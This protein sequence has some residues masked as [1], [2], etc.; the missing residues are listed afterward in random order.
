[1]KLILNS[2]TRWTA[3]ALAVG[4]LLIAAWPGFSAYR[5][6]V[7]EGKPV[8]AQTLSD[9]AKRERKQMEEAA[10]REREMREKEMKATNYAEGKKRDD[11]YE[12]DHDHKKHGDH[13]KMPEY[14]AVAA[15][16]GGALYLADKS[17][18]YRWTEA[19]LVELPRHP[20]KDAQALLAEE[21]VL[22]LADKEGLHRLEEGAKGWT[23]VYRG[24]ARSISRAG[25]GTLVLATKKEGLLGSADGK[26]WSEFALASAAPTVPEPPSELPE[27]RQ[28]EEN[29]AAPAE[30]ETAAANAP[31]AA[32]ESAASEATASASL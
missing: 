16:P 7:R 27:E 13:V 3:V 10:K 30:A 25:D 28:A 29:A 15:A 21:G 11:D 31:E 32:S 8:N 14:R 26:E 12:K 5:S 24:E 19:G 9:A 20:G 18:V 22:W 6:L 1:M 17:A 2:W 4:F 23:T